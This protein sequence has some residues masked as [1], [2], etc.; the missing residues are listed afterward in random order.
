MSE[1]GEVEG[2]QASATSVSILKM[3]IEESDKTDY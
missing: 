2:F 3:V 1:D